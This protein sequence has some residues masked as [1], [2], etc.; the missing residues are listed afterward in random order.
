MEGNGLPPDAAAY[1]FK[2]VPV[3]TK[4]ATVELE[5]AQNAWATAAG[6]TGSTSTVKLSSSIFAV[7]AEKINLKVRRVLQITSLVSPF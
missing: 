4:L 1:H 5:V 2:L 3:A 7:P 6:A